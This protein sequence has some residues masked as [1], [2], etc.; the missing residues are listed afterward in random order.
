MPSQRTMIFTVLGLLLAS[1][2][3]APVPFTTVRAQEAVVPDQAQSMSTKLYLSDSQNIVVDAPYN[4]ENHQIANCQDG[5]MKTGLF[6]FGMLPFGQVEWKPVASWDITLAG[7]L[8]VDNAIKFTLYLNSASTRYDCGFRFVLKA[9][10]TNLT[11]YME[12]PP[13]DLGGGVKILT[14]THQLQGGNLS[15]LRGG[16]ALK[17]ELECK[18]NGGGVQLLFA[19]QDYPSSMELVS[20]VI[21]VIDIHA[22]TAHIHVH[23]TDS[24]HAI[25]ANYRGNISLGMTP[26]STPAVFDIGQESMVAKWEEGLAAG[27]TSITISIGYRGVAEDNA[28]LWSFNANL[29]IKA[30]EAESILSGMKSGGIGI[31]LGVILIVAAIGAGVYFFIIRRSND[32]DFEEWDEDN[33]QP[34]GEPSRG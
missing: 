16:V 10:G 9:A 23:F 17:I 8:T 1:T 33:E 34:E 31:V 27:K 14:W 2:L 32:E 21:K 20:N 4:K 28:T 7:P 30:K 22:T 29:D 3:L 25:L 18:I 26:L 15:G 12:S 5:F 11:D 6:G 13:I 19:H 24:F